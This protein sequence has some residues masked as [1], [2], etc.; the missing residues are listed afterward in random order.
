MQAACDDFRHIKATLSRII[1]G[2]EELLNELL[3]NTPTEFLLV[4][5]VSFNIKIH[6]T[7]SLKPPL[8]LIFKYLDDEPFKTIQVFISHTVKQPNEEQHLGSYVNP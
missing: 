2:E 1:R 8:C 5:D 6:L 3:P 4:R 7:H